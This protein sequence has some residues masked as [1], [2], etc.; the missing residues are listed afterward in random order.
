M[1]EKKKDQKG[2]A[3]DEEITL[4]EAPLLD[5][6]NP[7]KYNNNK[8]EYAKPGLQKGATLD[9]DA[10]ELENQEDLEIRN[11]QIRKNPKKFLNPLRK[12]IKRRP[13]RSRGQSRRLTRLQTIQQTNNRDRRLRPLPR[14]HNHKHP[15]L[16]GAIASLHLHKHLGRR[17]LQ[18]QKSKK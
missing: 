3:Q 6:S 7:S 1:E 4:Q 11:T 16:P 14:L 5:E 15:P 8:L 10:I 18:P 17:I 13:L 12:R 9:F 2:E